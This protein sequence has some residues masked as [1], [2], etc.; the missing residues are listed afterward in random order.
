MFQSIT[1][2]LS[3]KSRQLKLSLENTYYRIKYPHPVILEDYLL[4]DKQFSGKTLNIV[5]ITHI[6]AEHNISN[7]IKPLEKLGNVHVFEMDPENN[8]KTWYARKQSRN[9]E[10]LDFLVQKKN[11]IDIIIFY[12]S[13]YTTSPAILEII[14]AMKVPMIN[15]GLDD[16]R[17]FR[18]RKGKDGIR[19]G[20]SDI[21]KYFDLSLTTSRSAI[22]KYL[23]EGGTPVYIP[24]AVNPD[25]Y[26]NP[27]NKQKKYDV[28]FV[29]ARY[30]IREEFVNY[31][32]QNGID[33]QAF[34]HGWENGSVSTE[35]MINLFNEAKIVLG[36]SSVGK[37]ENINIIKARDFEVPMTGNFYITQYHDELEQYFR[38]GNEIET[39]NNK[40][41]LLNKITHYLDNNEERKSIEQAGYQKAFSSY[42]VHSKYSN[43]MGHFD[44]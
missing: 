39:Y 38:I 15:E 12:I 24:Y 25:I 43:I 2:Q 22:R 20:N 8:R 34:G 16:E 41:D 42:N 37:S 21:C 10:L 3:E 4:T 35:K 1:A 23:A 14:R 6:V 18:S 28:I 31:L 19:R 26:I 40:N 32:T 11:T 29:G 36:F 7:T 33:I 30:G 17:K 44:L 5:Y 27:D 9:K 13:G